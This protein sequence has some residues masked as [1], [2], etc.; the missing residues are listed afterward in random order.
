MTRRV[1]KFAWFL[2]YSIGIDIVWFSPLML[3]V[4]TSLECEC[5]IHSLVMLYMWV[6]HDWKDIVYLLWSLKGG[7]LLYNVIDI[8]W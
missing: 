3:V 5:V 1:G 4:F 2:V 8:I 6:V 7:I